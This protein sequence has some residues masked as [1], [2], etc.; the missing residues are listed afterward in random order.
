MA[1][2][3]KRFVTV[4]GALVFLFSFA[5][6]LVTVA[7]TVSFW[8]CGE[9]VAC[10]ATMS[11]PHPPGAPLYIMVNRVLTIL[12]PFIDEVALRINLFSAFCGALTALF[13]FL[14]INRAVRFFFDPAKE[15]NFFL[16]L[17]PILGGFAGSLCM[18]Y[19]F[20][21]W[22]NAVESEVYAVS[23]TVIAI[24]IWL[25]LK[26]YDF[27]GTA[28]GDRLLILITY[29]GFVGIGFQLYT[30]I[31]IPLVFFFVILHDEDKRRHWQL[32]LIGFCILSVMYSISSFLTIGPVLLVFCVL[33]A[34]LERET[35]KWVNGLFMGV[36]AAWSLYGALPT[37][38]GDEFSGLN[39]ILGLCYLALAV[40][41]FVAT[42]RNREEERRKWWFCFAIVLVAFLGFSIHFEIPIRSYLDPYV[43]E[44]NPEV[45][46]TSPGDL[47]KKETWE[48]FV[49]YV[50]RK[51]YGNESMITRMFHRRGTFFSQFINH[52]HMGLGGYLAVQYFNFGDI[53]AGEISLGNNAVVRI[54]KLAAYLLPVFLVLWALVFVFRRNRP[55]ALYLG[56]LL[57]GTL[58]GLTLYM[59]FADG[60]I[61]EHRDLV[62]WERNGQQGPKPEPIQMEVRERDYFWNPGF[63]LYGIWLGIGFSALMIAMAA[64]YR[65]R[66]GLLGPALT[67]LLLAA[68]ALPLCVNGPIKTRAN[69]WVAYDYAFNLLNSCDRDAVL[70]TNGDNDT[71][72][73]WFAQEV[74]G[75]RRDVKV[76]NLSLLNTD[77]YIAQLWENQPKLDIPPVIFDEVMRPNRLSRA[78]FLKTMTHRR[79]MLKEPRK[80]RLSQWNLEIEIPDYRQA[81]FFRV[82]DYMILN[83]VHGNAGSR[84]IYFAV[85]VSDGNLMGLKP[86][87]IMEGLVY[88]L[89]PTV[90]T[91]R[92]DLDRT[93]FCLDNLFRFTH[94]GE[95]D[96]YLADD[97][98]KLLS[99]YAASFIGYVYEA[100]AELGAL[101]QEEKTL[102]D[103]IA[104]L[105][106]RKGAEAQLAA[107]GAE[108]A[109]VTERIDSI[110]STTRRQLKRCIAI[111]P[112]DWRAR[113]LAAQF[114]A[115]DGLIDSAA[116][117][118]KDGLKI[119]PEEYVYNANLGF[120]LR[121]GGRL[122]EAVPYLEKVINKLDPDLANMTHRET[123]GAL[124]ALMDIYS[125]SGQ[126]DKHIALLTRWTNAHPQDTRALQE[127][128]KLRTVQ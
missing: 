126:K 125:R 28:K 73:L 10:G 121:D 100:R 118:L 32:W 115:Q 18:A 42:V 122:Q 91:Q 123:V 63:L 37:A 4:F 106:A 67:V 48:K 55:V 87:L 12:L 1:Y 58:I 89:R 76:V 62:Q 44:N 21:G 49:Y 85:T 108:L 9:F 66:A 107:K 114:Y 39:F 19:S 120:L 8:D 82:Q 84:P 113:V 97:N 56:L 30:V 27:R 105:K 98:E 36:V 54:L 116:V 110:Y 46:I 64:R 7:P 95:K 13:A 79:N 38:A 78:D 81:S 16:K 102:Q 101:K 88:R 41:P 5:A 22:F 93:L 92:M 72:P 86:Y 99:N 34:L 77:W 68:P 17:T 117:P 65:S 94:L 90:Q 61:P 29:L 25:G 45:V 70:F 57:G 14:I 103:A 35:A 71:F 43:D 26:W 24:M 40:I 11:V 104:A 128:E 31:P 127:L 112:K 50:E 124:S 52:Q 53:N 83:I 47:L 59:N 80:V 69:N 60:T 75:I 15:G 23:N 109:G 33:W 20:T 6:Y 111:L 2:N 74:L 119:D 96:L 3:E 51:Q